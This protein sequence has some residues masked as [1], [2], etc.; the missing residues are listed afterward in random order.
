MSTVSPNILAALSFLRQAKLNL[1][2]GS[3]LIADSLIKCAYH[4]ILNDFPLDHDAPPLPPDDPDLNA[5]YVREFKGPIVVDSTGKLPGSVRSV[6]DAIRGRTIPISKALE[7]MRAKDAER[8]RNVGR[9]EL[10]SGLGWIDE[11]QWELP[12]TLLPNAA[13]ERYYENMEK[14]RDALARRLH[15]NEVRRNRNLGDPMPIWET[16]SRDDQNTWRRDADVIMNQH[17]ALVQAR[18]NG[19]PPFQVMYEGEPL[20]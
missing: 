1:D 9:A 6:A 20:S 3:P 4:A 18:I 13:R 12:D 5:K 2:A 7:A 11:K 14:I 8:D 16:L 10:P 17:P 19:L 15:R